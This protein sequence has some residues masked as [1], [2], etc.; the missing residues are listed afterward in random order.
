MSFGCA[1]LSGL[2]SPTRSE[3]GPPFRLNPKVEKAGLSLHL[4]DTVL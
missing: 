4:V 2:M 3:T 1:M